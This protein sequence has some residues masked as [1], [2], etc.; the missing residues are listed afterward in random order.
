MRVGS[1]NVEQRLTTLTAKE[2]GSPDHILGEIERLNQD[3]LVLPEAYPERPKR[4]IDDSLR[5]MGYR[6]VDARYDDK[7]REAVYDGMIPYMRILSRYAIQASEL[8][9]W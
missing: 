4:G 6:W 5:D 8:V 3:V 1:W 2:R 7:G 9:R